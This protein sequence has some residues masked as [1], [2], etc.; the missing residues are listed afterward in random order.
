MLIFT[1]KLTAADTATCLGTA[2]LDYGHREKARQRVTLNTGEAVG[3]HLPRGTVMSDGDQLGDDNG[4]VI[5]IAAAPERV[6]TVYADEARRLARFAYHLGNRHIWVQVGPGWLRYL[7]D[8]VL[9]DMVR[10]LGGEPVSET[11]PFEP[12]AGAYAAGGHHH[13]H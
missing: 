2:T 3:I 13:D 9:D 10:G 4:H 5:G 1:R 12:E 6:S 8:H 7:A 11:V